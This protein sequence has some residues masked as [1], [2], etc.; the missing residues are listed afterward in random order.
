MIP[1]IQ[2]DRLHKRYRRVEALRG[3]GLTL[4]PG[5]FFGLLGPNGAGKTTLI[6]T[7]VGLARPSEG[8]IRVFG[9]EVREEPVRVKALIG[10]SPQEPN[11]DRYFTVR[12]ILE[13]QGGYGGLSRRERGERALR[14]MEQFGLSRKADAEGWSLSGGM[15]KRT[16]VARS[17]VGHPKILILD[18]PSAGI[19]V[20]QRQELWSYLRGLNRDGTTI[21]LTTHYIDEAEELCDRVGIIHEGRIVEIGSP[22]ELIE[23]HAGPPQLVLQRGSLEE[24][25][26]KVVGKSIR[27]SEQESEGSD[28]SV[29]HAG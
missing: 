9:S 8:E 26:L 17:L 28:D 11:I 23:R 10:Y 15:I 19:D 16:M 20:E 12:K 13:F 27:E 7:I 4:P 29:S 5:E 1:A 6:K 21:L 2:I 24:V 22:Q 25:F 3:V 18:E 14:L